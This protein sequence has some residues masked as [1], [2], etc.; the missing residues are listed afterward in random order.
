MLALSKLLRR[1]ASYL[2]QG[3]R[4]TFGVYF[5]GT[6]R[7]YPSCSHYMEE[8]IQTHGVLRGIWLGIR[9]IGRCHPFANGGYDPVPDI[10]PTQH[11]KNCTH[12][13]HPPRTESQVISHG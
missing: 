2:L 12:A 6:C 4:A 8:A 1:L 13:S 5:G 11:H 7:F 3:Y 10:H 9:R